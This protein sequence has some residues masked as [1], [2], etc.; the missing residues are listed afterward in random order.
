M[1]QLKLSDLHA[2]KAGDR[3]YYYERPNSDGKGGLGMLTEKVEGKHAVRRVSSRCLC[4]IPP[5]PLSLV[6]YVHQADASSNLH[7]RANTSRAS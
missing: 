4:P 3:K 2:S 5:L 1:A 6:L 7:T